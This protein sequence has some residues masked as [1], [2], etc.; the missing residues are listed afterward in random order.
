MGKEANEELKPSHGCFL[1]D[2]SDLAHYEFWRELNSWKI[3]FLD[4]IPFVALVTQV[5]LCQQGCSVP[6]HDCACDSCRDR[7]LAP[8]VR[9]FSS[10][11][12]LSSSLADVSHK[13][14]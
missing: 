5:P 11:N 12:H 10:S 1:N 8:A 13:V 9:I 3:A 14:S 7:K 2:S 6:L 4:L